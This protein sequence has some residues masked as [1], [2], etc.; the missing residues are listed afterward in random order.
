[1]ILDYVERN[2]SAKDTAEGIPQWWVH[3][4]PDAVERALE[5][6]TGLSFMTSRTVPGMGKVYEFAPG[7]EEEIRQWWR[8]ASSD[9]G[10]G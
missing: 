3:R 4:P 6:L 7:R 9:I 1:M 5:L 8:R 10:D 2:P